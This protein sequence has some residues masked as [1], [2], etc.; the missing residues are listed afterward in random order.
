MD[1]Q[2]QDEQF[3]RLAIAEAQAAQS[4]G[5][6]PVGA[7]VVGP[8]ATILGRGQNRVLRDSD[9]T[10]HAEIVALREAGRRLGNYRILDPRRRLHPLRHPRTLRHVRQRNPART[11]RPPPL[12]RRRS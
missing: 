7:V 10:A 11:H 4:A 6:V 8:D 3:M 1:L 9:P 5:E 12:R 2:S